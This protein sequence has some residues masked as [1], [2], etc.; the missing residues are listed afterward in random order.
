[1]NPTKVNLD[2]GTRDLVRLEQMS[3]A[4]DEVQFL[5]WTL[6]GIRRILEQ[7]DEANSQRPFPPLRLFP[8]A[9]TFEQ[10]GAAIA[11]AI[12]LELQWPENLETAL[13]NHLDQNDP[14]IAEDF[15]IQLYL[16]RLL[17]QFEC[18][19][20]VIET[21]SHSM[22][23]CSETSEECEISGIDRLIDSIVLVVKKSVASPTRVAQFFSDLMLSPFSSDRHM[24]EYIRAWI[25][26]RRVIAQDRE[27]TCRAWKRLIKPYSAK[28]AS[29]GPAIATSL[30]EDG[31]LDSLAQLLGF[32]DSET[33]I[34][35]F[36]RFRAYCD[37]GCLIAVEADKAF[38]NR[39]R[40]TVQREE[41]IELVA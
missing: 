39:G 21:A 8:S 7:D 31:S 4:W 18:S 15:L 13:L 30:V 14:L 38:D 40:T 41:I 29:A 35:A 36:E 23:M 25:N 19:S 6:R 9:D 17:G 33:H 11:T 37:V 24:P 12:W 32:D 16:W 5:G 1:M 27:E 26:E 2:S 34:R 22:R 20:R 10:F 3:L 28:I